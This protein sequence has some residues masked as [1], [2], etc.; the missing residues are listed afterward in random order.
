MKD[1]YR[2]IVPII[3]LLLSAFLLTAF[4][5]EVSGGSGLLTVLRGKAIHISDQQ[6]TLSKLTPVPNRKVRIL[7]ALD[8]EYE[9]IIE[10]VFPSVVSVMTKSVHNQQVRNSS[11]KILL[12]PQNKSGQGS[13]VIVTKQGHIIT[14]YHVIAAQQSVTV[15]LIDG[16]TYPA[17]II[18]FDPSADI[19]VLK[20]NTDKPLKALKFGDSDQ[21]RTGHHVLAFG[22]PFNIGQSVTDGI[23]SARKVL[24]SDSEVGLFQTN[25]AINPGNSGGPLVNRNGEIIGINSRIFSPNKSD[26]S[27][28]GI[29]L[30]IPS[31]TV[32]KTFDDILQYKRPM[33]G[34]LGLYAEDITTED[35]RE[36]LNFFDAGGTV[37]QR[38]QPN[39]PAQKA[40]IQRYDVVTQFN[41]ID[42]ANQIQFIKLIHAAPINQPIDVRVWRKDRF[43]DLKASITLVDPGTIPVDQHHLSLAMQ[44]AILYQFGINAKTYGSNDAAVVTQILPNS[45]AY[46]RLQIND[47]IYQVNDVQI[48]NHVQLRSI[49]LNQ[50]TQ[51]ATRIYVERNNERLSEPIIVPKVTLKAQS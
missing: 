38:V 11:G 33:R 17:Q 35:A 14:N 37:V 6:V 40:G 8:E 28:R 25:V 3:I 22:E 47:I 32:K 45:N 26:I 46:R 24:R 48:K 42:V 7:K 10:A 1:L 30:A 34:Y 15:R 36:I 27:F 19:A 16:S 13:G 20:I 21:V 50:A 23:I 44:N 4:V 51:G 12:L 2:R 41:G 29:S 9:T 31:N 5:R 43:L 39:S 18:G 49:I